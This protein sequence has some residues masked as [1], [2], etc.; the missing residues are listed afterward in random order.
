MK[1]GLLDCIVRWNSLL[2]KPFMTG[3]ERRIYERLL[4]DLGSRQPLDI[5]EYGSGFSTLYFARFLRSKG[6]R[7][8]IDSMEH[9]RTWHLDIKHRIERAGLGQDVTLHLSEFIP[10]CTPPKTPQE[11]HYVN[12][13]R[14][15]GKKFDL[16]VVDGRFRRCCLET[17][18]S[19]LKPG[20]IVFLHD[21]ERTFYHAPLSRFKHSVF[22]DGGH[23]YPFEPREH[24]IW[25]G[26][27]DN[28][29]IHHYTG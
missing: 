21:A 28:G 9:D 12:G 2:Q 7:F 16:I 13:P 19:C 3:R 23:H 14:S 15:R 17:A 10:G 4:L 11:L 24:K 5:F 22:I 26:S 6:I 29:H 1:I 25:L 27:L 20:G 8:H 18:M